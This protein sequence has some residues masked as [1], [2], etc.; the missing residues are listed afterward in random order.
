MPV[1]NSSLD[2]RREQGQGRCYAEPGFTS[3]NNDGDQW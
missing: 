3:A 2:R 1:F